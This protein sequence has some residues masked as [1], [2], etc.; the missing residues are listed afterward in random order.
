MS[1]ADQ[2]FGRSKSGH[3]ADAARRTYRRLSARY[4]S[5]RRDRP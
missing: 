1:H 5:V 4:A 3:L 2:P